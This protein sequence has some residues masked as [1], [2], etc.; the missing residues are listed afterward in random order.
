MVPVGFELVYVADGKKFTQG[1]ISPYTSGMG[2]DSNDRL[3]CFSIDIL[4]A[5]SGQSLTERAISY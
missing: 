2:R 1:S 4:D 5:I 3:L